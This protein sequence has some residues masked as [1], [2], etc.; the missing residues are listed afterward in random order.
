MVALHYFI[1]DVEVQRKFVNTFNLLHELSA[2]WAPH[3]EVM[4]Q[5]WQAFS[6]ESV[7]AMDQYSWNLLAH[8]EFFTAVV[9]KVKPSRFVIGLNKVLWLVQLL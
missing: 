1:K 7:S 3:S 2:D 5:V 4:V 9:A 6:A 8:I